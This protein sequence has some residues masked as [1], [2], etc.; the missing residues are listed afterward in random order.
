MV[1]TIRG[2]VPIDLECLLQPVIH[3]KHEY[4]IAHQ[5]ILLLKMLQESVLVTAFLPDWERHPNFGGLSRPVARHTNKVLIENDVGMAPRIGMNN[6]KLIFDNHTP[7][8]ST[9]DDDVGNFKQAILT[10]FKLGYREIVEKSKQIQEVVSTM[11]AQ[12]NSRVVLRP[13]AF[14]QDLIDTC[15]QWSVTRSRKTW[16]LRIIEK[17]KAHPLPFDSESNSIILE[18]ETEALLN[19]E[20]PIFHEAM[21]PPGIQRE[22]GID[23]V[24]RRLANL[25]SLDIDFQIRLISSSLDIHATHARPNCA[26]ENFA[27]KLPCSIGSYGKLKG[28]VSSVVSVIDSAAI[29]LPNGG[30]S[31]LGVARSTANSTVTLAPIGLDLYRGI[32]G[33]LVF[34][35][36]AKDLVVDVSI[37]NLI[38]RISQAILID[39]YDVNGWHQKTWS[40]GIMLGVGGALYAFSLSDEMAGT[41]YVRENA[42]LFLNLLSTERFNSENLDLFSGSAGAAIACL[43]AFA[44]SGD[45]RFS[46][47]AKSWCNRILSSYGKSEKNMSVGLSH[48]ISGLILALCRYDLINTDSAYREASILL[49]DLENEMLENEPNKS[50][51]ERRGFWCNGSI[52]RILI[53]SEFQHLNEQKNVNDCLKVYESFAST[54]QNSMQPIDLCC[55]QFGLMASLY[56]ALN[57]IGHNAQADRVSFSIEECLTHRDNLGFNWRTGSDSIQPSLFKGACGLAYLAA[58]FAK[59]K[60]PGALLSFQ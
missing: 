5:D 40:P 8:G 50:E 45:H 1:A 56:Q 16:K 51:F 7:I 20:I 24:K 42:D 17:L 31:W 57:N 33:I 55:G 22:H 26:R 48:G 10:G 12:H 27:S 47:L 43:K 11:G 38:N 44:S 21:L 34:L 13:T 29:Y 32:A 41:A 28:V 3:L 35:V 60:H 15:R 49:R 36:E 52:G 14:Y 59:R 25:S 37:S 9:S 19:F 23:V 6:R 30:V 39:L 54:Q 18:Y 53:R 4:E 2:P 46:V 58:L